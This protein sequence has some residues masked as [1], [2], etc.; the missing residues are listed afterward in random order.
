LRLIEFTTLALQA[1]QAGLDHLP[2]RRVDHHRHAGDV[3][4]GGDQVRGRSSWHR[5]PVEHALVHVHV[6]DLRAVLD[7]L[8][9]DVE[10][11]R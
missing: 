6:D 11:G 1:L 3:R 9:R 7:L 10:R 5:R 4:L 8:P 2:A